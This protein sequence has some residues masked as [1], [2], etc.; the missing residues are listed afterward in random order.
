MKT[1]SIEQNTFVERIAKIVSIIFHPLILPA[2]A[3]TFLIVADRS[4]DVSQKLINEGVAVVFSVLLLPA[5][6]FFLKR[7]GMVDSADITIRE[8]RIN[9]L[10]VGT[11]F[12][13][14]GFLLLKAVGASSLIQGL[15]FCYWTNTLLIVLITNW[16]KISIHTTATSGPLVVLAYQF[17]S[18]VLPFFGLIPLVGASRLILKRHTFAQVLAG[19]AIGVLM[20]ALQIR[21]FFGGV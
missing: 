8:Q 17:G 11:A 4:N 5:Y 2:I 14:T 1:T 20:T 15:M 9:P 13:F 12:Y 16:W 3:F 21:L 19:A 6:I 7:K 18:I 10:L